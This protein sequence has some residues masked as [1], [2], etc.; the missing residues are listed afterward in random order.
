[1]II[2]KNIFKDIKDLKIYEKIFILVV[3]IFLIFTSLFNLNELKFFWESPL[4]IWKKVLQGLSGFTAFTGI[5]CV[6]MVGKGKMSNYFWGILNVTFYGFYAFSVGY[7]GDALLNLLFFLPFNFIGIFTWKNHLKEKTIKPRKFTG[8]DFLT[9]AFLTIALSL[10]FYF[11]IPV[12]DEFLHTK[13]LQENKN[14]SYKYPFTQKALPHWF[15]ALTNSFSITAQILMLWRFKNQWWLWIVVNVLQ[16]I[17]YSGIN[18][19]GVDVP[20]IIMWGFFLINAIYSLWNWFV[21]ER[22]NKSVD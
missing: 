21:L 11:L 1:M 3:G 22:K 19:W 15:D 6:F 9:F 8:L 7:T 20:M 10:S 5:I 12:I 2:F 18:G 16:I 17:M 4:P 13:I 14:S